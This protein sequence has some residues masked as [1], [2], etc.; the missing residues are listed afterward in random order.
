MKQIRNIRIVDSVK[1]TLSVV[2]ILLTAMATLRSLI[3]SRQSK[4]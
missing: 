1:T 3:K 2:A 4:F